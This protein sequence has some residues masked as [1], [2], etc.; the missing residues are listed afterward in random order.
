M[1]PLNFLATVCIIS[2]ILLFSS[3]TNTGNA[4]Y[5]S[6]VKNTEYVER[7]E[8][9]E[10]VIQKNDLLSITIASLNPDA[11]EFFNILNESRVRTTSATNSIS[12]AVGYLVD[13]DGNIQFPFLG[14]VK[15]AGLTKKALKESIRSELVNRKLLIDPIV[16]IRYLNYK[17]SVLGEVARPSVLTVPNEKITLLEALG[18]AGDLTIYANRDNVL[19]IRE[20]QGKKK[21]VRLDLTSDELFSSPYYYLKS[22]DIVYVE[23]NK[24]KIAAS[25]AARQWLPLV[26][27]GLTLVVVSID[28]LAR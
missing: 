26:L 8:S 12:Q 27:S 4:V 24:T 9:L 23:P 25:G 1:K 17:V 18:L 28:R 19:L 16:D 14:K 11:T 6:K 15:A 7:V 20:E 10:P 13:Q 21:L 5:F 2:Y 3:C 22:N